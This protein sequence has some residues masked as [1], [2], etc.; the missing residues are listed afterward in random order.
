MGALL[1]VRS[2]AVTLGAARLVRDVSLAVASGQVHALIGE[3]GCGK[4]STAR[5]LL[6]L[7]PTG[8][9]V[10]GTVTV[11]GAA[12]RRGLVTMVPQDAQSALNPVMSVGEQLFEALTV[13]QGLTGPAMRDAALVL[14]GAVGL[15][16]GQ[17]LLRAFAHQLSGGMRQRVLIAAALAASPRVLVADE[18]TAALDAALR[19]Q[20]LQLFKSLAATRGLAVLL[21]THELAAV[22][23]A[24]S[25]VS[26]MY[27]GTIVE[28]GACATVLSRPRHPY[29]RALLAARPSAG[30]HPI[31]GVAPSATA[32]VEGCSFRPRC[33]R[34]GQGCLVSPPL[35]GGVACVNPEPA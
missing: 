24:A 3:S 20:V 14:L 11:D 29:T 31:E 19:A 16:E 18:P 4:S 34:A 7:S 23:L 32:V 27:A 9:V 8:A 25:E 30:F 2:L 33:G 22:E 6:G 12:P 1:E 15:T 17:A 13:H 28:Q 35:A 21:I 26:V 5:A 10:S